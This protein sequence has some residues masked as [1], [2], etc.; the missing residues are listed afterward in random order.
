VTNV[1][2]TIM[3]P[4]G[5]GKRGDDVLQYLITGPG[6]KSDRMSAARVQLIEIYP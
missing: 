6:C 1:L 2:Q 4:S 5:N 3:L